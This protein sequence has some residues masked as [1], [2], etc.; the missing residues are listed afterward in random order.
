MLAK[1]CVYNYT[2]KDPFQLYL[3]FDLWYFGR[4][5]DLQTISGYVSSACNGGGGAA[6]A[7]TGPA[8]RRPGTD[9]GDEFFTAQQ[10]FAAAAC[11]GCAA[12]GWPVARDCRTENCILAFL[13]MRDS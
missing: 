13:R 7:S 4:A 3:L 1:F 9:R 11:S 8:W 12:G 10:N 5:L 2:E 6:L